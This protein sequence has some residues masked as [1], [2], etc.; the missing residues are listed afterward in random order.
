MMKRI[1]L[2]LGSVAAAAVT[3]PGAA[4]A[5]NAALVGTVTTWSLKVTGPAKALQSI[6]A[7]TT[8]TQALKASNRLAAVA[9]AGASAIARQTPS[10]AKGRSLK[11]LSG[12][13]FADFAQ[14][15]K[16]LASAIRDVQAGRSGAAVTA[17]VNKAVRLAKDGGALLTRA[18]KIIPKLI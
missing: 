7:N 12:K 5:D 15:G 16:L 4:L 1:V 18:S 8:T 2:A 9:T 17:K 13:A 3:L 6:N 10:S 14:S 11:V